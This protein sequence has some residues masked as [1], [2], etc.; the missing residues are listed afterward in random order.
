[1]SNRGQGSHIPMH[2]LS[3]VFMA[4]TKSVAFQ[5]PHG[6]HPTSGSPHGVPGRLSAASEYAVL[7]SNS[8]SSFGSVMR[9]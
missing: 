5:T 7:C 8:E 9:E 2:V 6:R 1:M 4:P 3:L